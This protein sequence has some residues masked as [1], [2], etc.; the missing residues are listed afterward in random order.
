MSRF[1]L[2]SFQ[3]INRS[4]RPRTEDHLWHD[5]QFAHRDLWQPYP[6]SFPPRHVLLKFGLTTDRTTDSSNCIKRRDKRGHRRLLKR[7]SSPNKRNR[8]EISMILLENRHQFI[9]VCFRKPET[10]SCKKHLTM[11][12]A[13]SVFVGLVIC[14]IPLAVISSLYVQKSESVRETT[15]R[16]MCIPILKSG[17]Q[18]QW[19]QL[20]KF[21]WGEI[22]L[23]SL[24]GAAAFL[25]GS[26]GSSGSSS[27]LP[28]QC[29]SYTINSDP[30]RLST[31][32]GCTSC[33]YDTSTWLPTGWYRFTDGAG[34]QLATVPSST[35]MCGASYPGYYNGTYPST[36]GSTT[37]GIV[38]PNVGGN[39]CG[40]GYFTASISVTNCNGYYVFYLT[41]TASTAAR[42]CTTL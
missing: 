13:A 24:Q 42:Y 27:G 1:L 9:L 39:L 38:C 35:G 6:R 19:Q 14:G 36:A 10:N 8:E 25:P 33:V 37:T 17:I 4:R 16:V 2:G 23:Q 12:L 34:T 11:K 22:T 31:Y 41:S 5:R 28:T 40:A 29:S 15:T 32:T 20:G 30:T 3:R 26:S 7:H 18:Q 21:R